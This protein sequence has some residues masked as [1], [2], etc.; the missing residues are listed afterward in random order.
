[1]RKYAYIDLQYKEFEFLCM[2]VVMN[3]GENLD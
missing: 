2:T 1:M 3:I